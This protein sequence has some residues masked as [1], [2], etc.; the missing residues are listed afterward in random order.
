MSAAERNA[1]L[2]N[3]LDRLREP[4]RSRLNVLREKTFKASTRQFEHSPP[5]SAWL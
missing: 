4:L 2:F 5:S 3:D 1:S